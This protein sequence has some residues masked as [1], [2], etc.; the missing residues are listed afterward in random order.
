M[1]KRKKNRHHNQPADMPLPETPVVH[2]DGQ[3]AIPDNS[4][5]PVEPPQPP[6]HEKTQETERPFIGH[7]D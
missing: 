2:E 7:W 5:V 6:K 1:S 3:E 4:T